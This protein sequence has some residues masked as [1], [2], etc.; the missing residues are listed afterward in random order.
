MTSGGK[1]QVNGVKTSIWAAAFAVTAI[2]GAL[3][4][5]A[6]GTAAP[7]P[8]APTV[9]VIAPSDPD[10]SPSEPPPDGPLTDDTQAVIQKAIQGHASVA[11]VIEANLASPEK[12]CPAATPVILANPAAAADLIDGAKIHSELTE[13]LAQCLSKIQQSMKTSNP[14]GAELIGSL[15]ATAPAAFQAA[16]AVALVPEGADGPAPPA[17]DGGGAAGPGDSGGGGAAAGTGGTADGG[18]GS[19]G[20][21]GTGGGGG[22]VG[23][24]GFGSFAG[25]GGGGIGGGGNVTPSTP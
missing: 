7:E 11:E 24:V 14:E 22:G 9:T 17:D 13:Q 1:R 6:Q 3:R 4:A 25:G 20:G 15:I 12:I 10:P 2:L 8:D 16:Y 21:G 5:D 23:T 19:S 18:S